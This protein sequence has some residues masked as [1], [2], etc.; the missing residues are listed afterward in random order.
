MASIGLCSLY[1]LSMTPKTGP[2]LSHGL[3]NESVNKWINV[4]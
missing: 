4:S 1:C 3:L 2:S